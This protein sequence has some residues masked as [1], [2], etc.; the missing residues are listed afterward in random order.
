VL[1][2]PIFS[3]EALTTPRQL[4][5]YLVRSGYIAALF[6]LMY[7]AAQ[8]TFGWQQTRSV[9]DLARFGSLVFQVFSLVQLTLVL[10]FAL[11]FVANNVSQEKE[12]RTLILLLMTDMRDRE[13]VLGK[14]SAS[15]LTVAV[16]LAASLP[17]FVMVHMLG[18]VMLSQ[19]LWSVALAAAAALAVGS[20]GTLVAFW[21]E[22]TFQTLA[23]GVIGLLAF[24]G[25]VE[26]VILLAGP[27][28][29]AGRA[30]ALFNPYRGLYELLS[31]L[32]RHAG[33][34]P[35]RV[36]ALGPVLAMVGMA[37]GLNTVTIGRLRVWN[38]SRFIFVQGADEG[39][40]EE[41]ETARARREARIRRVKGN[42]V[43]WREVATRAYG[44]K[45]FVI[46]LAYLALAVAVCWSIRDAVTADPAA[47]PRVLDMLTVP[48][49]ALVALTILAVFLV[50]AQAVTSLTGERDGKTLELLLV[51]DITAQE[52]VYGKLLGALYN[53]KELIAVPLAMILWFAAAGLVSI[54]DAAYLLIG[55]VTLIVFGATLGL[56]SG[57]SY[58]R[59]RVAVSNSVGT[60][61]F[62]F[63]GVFIFMILL[64]EASG[65]FLLQF[66]SFVVFIGVGS[67]ALYASLRHKIPSGALS[68]AAFTLPFLTFYAVTSYFI[69]GTLGVC[70][71]LV[72]AYGFPTV[73]MLIPAVSEFDMA[74]GRTTLDR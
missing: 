44:R 27:E 12:R 51:T 6:L 2:G 41:G 60:V 46:K 63:V 62:L 14:L 61:F 54:E 47:L 55:T 13:L 68:L 67:V 59:S 25:L 38:P 34:E 20:W 65:S 33:L 57:L 72:M 64:V 23:V 26:T 40:D 11:L 7:T 4:R 8:V 1:A 28:S 15:L 53:T 35:A 17:A 30:A 19:V 22:K 31:P 58:D 52:F 5:H 9:G 70:L 32:Q 39:A 50:N 3:R 48:G 66:Q 36:S 16:L 10:F 71:T 18:G 45:T 49:F 21:R 42:P 29:T 73:A 43:Y 37:L 69:G 24:L 56:H 74:L